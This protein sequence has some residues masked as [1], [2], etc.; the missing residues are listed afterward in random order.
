MISDQHHLSAGAGEAHDD[1]VARELILAI[2]EDD[3]GDLRRRRPTRTCPVCMIGRK[4][5]EDG[6]VYATAR[7]R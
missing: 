6:R 1:P 5:P 2:H 4:G 3:P 7:C